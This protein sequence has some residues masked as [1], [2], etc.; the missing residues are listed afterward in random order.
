MG[1]GVVGRGAVVGAGAGSTG[2][3]CSLSKVLPAPGASN[4]H[5]R[6][7]AN[8]S[9]AQPRWRTAAGARLRRTSRVARAC[10]GRGLR[11][12]VPPPEAAVHS[13]PQREQGDEQQQAADHGAHHCTA[14]AGMGA[15]SVGGGGGGTGGGCPG[16]G[17]AAA[18]GVTRAHAHMRAARR[19]SRRA[20]SCSGPRGC[21]GRA[22]GRLPPPA[23]AKPCGRLTERRRSG[24]TSSPAAA[25]IP[26]DM[27]P[28]GA[29]S[30]ARPPALELNSPGRPRAWDIAICCAACCSWQAG[31]G[32]LRGRPHH[33][34]CGWRRCARLLGLQGSL[35]VLQEWGEP[36][37]PRCMAG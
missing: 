16:W 31:R 29:S 27:L 17:W 8:G 19:Q 33:R 11:Y 30:A 24:A 5:I 3:C 36:R 37:C 12:G 18:A 15:G 25:I 7:R 34:N 22:Q 32:G 4:T 35:Q 14:R 26:A 20:A 6:I 1:S 9:E 13:L 23:P 28:E 10:F 21:A 2:R